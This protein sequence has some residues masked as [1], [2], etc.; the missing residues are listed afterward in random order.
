MLSYSFQSNRLKN[1]VVEGRRLKA[2]P[3]CGF[4][5]E[6]V[7]CRF[8]HQARVHQSIHYSSSIHYSRV[9]VLLQCSR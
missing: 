7:V 4:P 9:L 1:R 8:L 6:A 2:S 5:I 3:V